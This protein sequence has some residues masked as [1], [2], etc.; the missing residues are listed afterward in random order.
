[1]LMEEKIPFKRRIHA[2]GAGLMV[3]GSPFAAF[4][5]FGAAI[6]FL[7]VGFLWLGLVAFVTAHDHEQKRSKESAKS[8]DV[9]LKSVA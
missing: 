1:M 2:I 8:P 6:M 3:V 9:K 5:S 4:W 7:F